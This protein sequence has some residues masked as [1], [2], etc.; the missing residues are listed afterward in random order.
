MQKTTSTALYNPT[1]LPINREP[2]YLQQFMTLM[3]HISSSGAFGC[4]PEI[5]IDFNNLTKLVVTC[6][7]KLP[8]LRDAQF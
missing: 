7:T 1:T 2:P 3:L 5:R 8:L 6:C 4:N